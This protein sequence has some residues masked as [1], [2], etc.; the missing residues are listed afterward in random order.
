MTGSHLA[1]VLRAGHFAVTGEIGGPRSADGRHVTASAQAQVGY[2]DAVNVG[3]NA[4]ARAEMSPVAGAASVVEAGL[5][6][7]MQLTTRDRNRLALG[8]EMLGGWALG[9]RNLLCLGGDPMAFGEEPHAGE[10]RDL[11]VPGLIRIAV[12]LREEGRLPS[13]AEI[14]SPPRYFVGVVDEPLI[15]DYDVHHL[16]AKLDAGAEFVQTQIAYDL[17]GLAAWADAVRPH[18]LFERASFLVGVAPLRSFRMARWM[19]DRLPGVAVPE[20]L[21][22]ILEEAGDE[23]EAVGIQLTVDLIG[24]L[25]RI[26]GVA[27]IHLMC[28]GREDTVGKVVEAAGLLPRPTVQEVGAAPPRI[29]RR[30]RP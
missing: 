10:V 27:G 17:E 7:I 6:P 19:N 12:G 21:L 9:A 1:R 2:I 24:H 18:G 25:R 16:E 5:E 11:S 20:H 28:L 14:E 22:R 29:R 13:G 4:V 26:P 8:S 23:E 3:D 15:E 30:D